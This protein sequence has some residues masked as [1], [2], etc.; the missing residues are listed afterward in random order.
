MA[1]WRWPMAR[2]GKRCELKGSR[3]LKGCGVNM[4]PRG[5][6]NREAQNPNTNAK[7]EQR[8][9][10]NDNEGPEHKHRTPQQG[11][12]AKRTAGKRE[13]VNHRSPLSRPFSPRNIPMLTLFAS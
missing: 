10:T 7:T 13:H 12:E 6:H 4:T 5:E 11:K 9:G 1:R 8:A 3:T 2:A